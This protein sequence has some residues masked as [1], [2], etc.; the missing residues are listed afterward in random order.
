MHLTLKQRFYDEDLQILRI[1]SRTSI[2]EATEVIQL[3][4]GFSAKVDRDFF[5][6]I[7]DFTI[8]EKSLIVFTGLNWE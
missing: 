3:L 6:R 1:H 7:S 5:H 2:I 8:P 4:E